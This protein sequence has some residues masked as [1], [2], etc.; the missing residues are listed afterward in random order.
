MHVWYCCSHYFV[1]LSLRRMNDVNQGM[2]TAILYMNYD[3]LL[4][5][6]VFLVNLYYV[7]IFSTDM[8]VALYIGFVYQWFPVL[9]FCSKCIHDYCTVGPAPSMYCELMRTGLDNDCC[10]CSIAVCTAIPILYMND[11]YIF[12]YNLSKHFSVLLYCVHLRCGT[13]IPYAHR[14]FMRD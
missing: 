6:L 8:F 5:F 2:Y 12:H 3:I 9:P 14:A 11:V 10:W 4:L 1:L 7:H 13:S